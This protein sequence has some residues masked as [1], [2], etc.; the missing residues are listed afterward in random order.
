VD[1]A[2][3]LIDHQQC[4]PLGCSN[5]HFMGPLVLCVYLLYLSQGVLLVLIIEKIAV[6]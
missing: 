6:P 5:D 1:I 4:M 3:P 2:T